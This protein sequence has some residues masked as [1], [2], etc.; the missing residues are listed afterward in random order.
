MGFYTRYFPYGLACLAA[1]ARKLG[2]DATVLDADHDP[3]AR[4][5]DYQALSRSYPSYLTEVAQRESRLWVEMADTLRRLRPDWVGLTALTAKMASV[6]MTASMVREILPDCPI[7]VGGSHAAVRS[8]ELLDNA[9]DVDAVVIGEGEPL[10]EKIL[11]PDRAQLI[12]LG[13]SIPGLVTRQVSSKADEAPPALVETLSPPLRDCFVNSG[14]SREDLGLVMTARGCPFACT[15]CFSRGL[16]RRKVR[17]VPLESL[18]RELETLKTGLGVKHITFKDDVFS[19]RRDRTI[20]LCGILRDL[21]L[22]WDCV[23]RVDIIDPELLDIMRKCG[24]TGIKIGVETGSDRIM[25]DLRRPFDKTLIRQAASWLR[26]SGIHWTA[27]FMMGFPGETLDDVE[28]THNFMLDLSP[29]FAS[30]SGFEA[31]PGTELFDKARSMDIVK[32]RMNREEFFRISPH[33][34]YFSRRDRGMVLP[35]GLE[36]SELEARMQ[37]RFHTYNARFSKLL[38]RFRARV[39]VWRG[40]PSVVLKD[41]GRLGSWLGY[42]RH[43]HRS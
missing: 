12:E 38:K 14:Y 1:E 33:D 26:K 42:G 37:R 36:Y 20:T 27:Y 29:D 4:G 8:E 39:A 41:A 13:N 16:W 25:G 15:Y 19:L 22:T 3:A 9:F 18:A 23:T 35:Q 32:E 2:H 6:F 24:C 43:F 31:F 10:L 28:A 17:F 34:Y 5:I 7:V 40:E 21:R 11:I 30:L